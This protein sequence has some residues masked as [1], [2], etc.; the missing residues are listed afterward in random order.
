M[1]SGVGALK[2]FTALVWS[3]AMRF[4]AILFDE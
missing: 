3:N 4:N 1:Q 2:G